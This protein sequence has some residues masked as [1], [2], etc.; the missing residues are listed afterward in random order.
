MNIQEINSMVFRSV[1]SEHKDSIKRYFLENYRSSDVNFYIPILD[2]ILDGNDGMVNSL[3]NVYNKKMEGVDTSSIDM[4]VKLAQAVA[5][6]GLMA[7]FNVEKG[8]VFQLYTA[9]TKPF[10]IEDD[11]RFTKEKILELNKQGVVHCVRVDIKY[12][13]GTNNFDVKLVNTNKNTRVD[14]YCEGVRSGRFYVTPYIVIDFAIRFFQSLLNTSNALEVTQIKDDLV[15][16]RLISDNKDVL[17][18]YADLESFAETLEPL[19]YPLE[20]FFYAPVVGADSTTLGLTRIDL[21]D[22]SYIKEITNINMPKAK[23]GKDLLIKRSVVYSMLS[24]LYYK[25]K[26]T[27]KE[28]VSNIPN[29]DNKLSGLEFTEGEGIP[30]VSSLVSYLRSLDSEDMEKVEKLIPGFTD[31]VDSAKEVL[32]GNNLCEWTV[33]EGVAS[34]LTDGSSFKMEEGFKEILKDGIYRVTIV[35]SNGL[36]SVLTVTNSD[37]YLKKLYGK[38]YFINYES[39]AVRLKFLE[40]SIL[41]PTSLNGALDYYGFD[42]LDDYVKNEVIYLLHENKE[43]GIALMKSNLVDMV[44]GNKVVVKKKA[45]A[46]SG[47]NNLV[48]SRLAFSSSGEYYR[49]IDIT[50]VT[51]IIKVS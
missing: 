23:S 50:K 8:C 44:S 2:I 40:N 19:Y 49:Y 7:G 41:T 39:Q 10:G 29:K 48:L 4:D 46:R 30:R 11:A 47:N 22:V 12:T 51:K 27:Y 36:P 5:L 18:K 35:K 28:I 31:K 25:D 38:N 20:G 45:A 1:L 6:D 26:D 14:L 9:N 13:T 17:K 16:T 33:S 32:S 3:L 42:I 21:L 15:K 34:S 37:Y 43:E 24:D